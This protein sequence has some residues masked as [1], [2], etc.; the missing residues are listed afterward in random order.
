L[1][2]RPHTSVALTRSTPHV[3][4]FGAEVGSG[5][6]SCTSSSAVMLAIS[7]SAARPSSPARSTV[8]AKPLKIQ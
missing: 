4:S 3:G 5:S 8:A 6:G 1:P 2:N 7:G